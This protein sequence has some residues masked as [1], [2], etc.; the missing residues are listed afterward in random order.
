MPGIITLA[1]GSGGRGTFEILESV[2]LSHLSDNMKKLEGGVGTDELDD[3]AAIPLPDGSYLV[4][5][6]DAYTVNPPFFPGGN[7]GELAASGTI[8]DILMMGAKPMAILDSIVVEEG[9]PIS[10]LRQITKSL[11]DILKKYDIKLIG[12]D[13]KTMPKENLDKV[14]ITTA[15]IGIADRLIIDSNLKPGDKIII[16]GTIAEHGAAILAAQEG[17]QVEGKLKSDAEPLM[18]LMI[19]LLDE[20]GKFIH[21]AQDPTRGGLAET[22]NEWASKSGLLIRI[23]E[24]SVPIRDEVRSFTELMGID[25]FTLACEGR[26][27]LAV[28]S[29]MSEEILS[30]ITDLGFK[31]ASIIGNAEE[32]SKYGGNVVLKTIAGGLRL[33]ERPSGTIVPRIC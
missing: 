29:D 28:D 5:S 25:P 18:D 4:F 12:G 32:S 26:A 2:I 27:V 23:S 6:I 3:G 30:F 17:L 11:L 31:D 21:A 13:F 9:Y 8:N 15:G 10:E 33:L 16:S 20:Y 22:L 7:I 24:E 19:P 14:L 1:H